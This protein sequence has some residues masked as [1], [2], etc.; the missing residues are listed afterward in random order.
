MNRRDFLKGAAIAP[1]GGAIAVL[2]LQPNPIGPFRIENDEG[3]FFEISH[4]DGAW[5]IKTSEMYEAERQHNIKRM[6][7]MQINPPTEG[8]FNAQPLFHDPSPGELR[9]EN[10]TGIRV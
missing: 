9:I 8:L 5:H 1:I 2:T 3:G 4:A 10:V 7:A 6:S